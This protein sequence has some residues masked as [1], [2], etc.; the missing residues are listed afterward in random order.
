MSSDNDDKLGPMMDEFLSRKRK[1]EYPSLSEFVQRHP[2]LENEIR[3]LFPAI[4]MMEQAEVSEPPHRHA[5]VMTSNGKKLNRL[6]DYRII[7]EIGR[8]GM[9]V[10]YEAIQESLGRHVAIKLLPWQVTPGDTQARRFQREARIAASL[11]H[12]NIVP[13]YG[14]GYADS[15]HFLA[16]QFIH[17]QSL[18]SVLQELRHIQR[19]KDHSHIQARSPSQ[20]T[21]ATGRTAAAPDGRSATD[22]ATR[23]SHVIANS[24]V[25]GRD[26]NDGQNVSSTSRS[27]APQSGG[28]AA[29]SVSVL[30]SSSGRISNVL[31]YRRIAELMASVADALDFAHMQGVLHRDIKP[32]NLMLDIEGGIWITDFGLAKAGD[33]TDSHDNRFDEDFDALTQSGDIVGTLRYLAPERFRGSNDRRSDVYSLG[34]TLYEFLTLEPAF[35]NAD[36]ATLIHAITT[37]SCPAPRTI[38]ADIP[39]DLE[40]IV[41]KATQADPG[42]RYQSARDMA[43]DLRRFLDAKPIVA[44]RSS[45]LKRIQLWCRRNP[46]VAALSC[47]AFSLLLMIA[48]VSTYS[49]IELSHRQSKLTESLGRAIDA[50]ARERSA[51]RMAT[52]NLFDAYAA[53]AGSG[54]ESHRPGRRFDGLEAISNASALRD[55]IAV[56]DDDVMKL[57][58][59]AIACMGLADIAL[60]VDR[61]DEGT[62]CPFNRWGFD[63]RIEHYARISSSTGIEI[64]TVADGETVAHF[65]N[66]WS[67]TYPPFT[68]FSPDDRYVAIL[69]WH[70]YQ[71][72]AIEIWDTRDGS[73]ILPAVSVDAE[74]YSRSIA[75][76]GDSKLAAFPGRNQIL[77]FNLEMRR[78]VGI[79]PVDVSPAF[80]RFSAADSRVVIGLNNKVGV[81]DLQTT[82][83]MEILEHTQYVADAAF[84]HSGRYLAT[85]CYDHQVYVWNLE[86]RAGPVTTCSGH[87]SKALRVEF[88][89][90]DQLLM[91]NAW[92]DT[93]R[94]WNPWSGQQ[95]IR[96]ERYASRFSSDGLRIA[97]QDT[98]VSVGRWRVADSIACR[99]LGWKSGDFGIYDAAFNQSS[100]LLAH[101]AA[102]QVVIRDWP[103]GEVRYV[104]PFESKTVQCQFAQDDRFLYCSGHSHFARWNCRHFADGNSMDA[105][106]SRQS[107]S[108]STTV[109]FDLTRDSRSG[110]IH[111]SNRGVQQLT[112]TDADMQ[113]GAEVP[114]HPDEWIIET[115]DDGSLYALAG[116]HLD[117]VRVLQNSDH[118]V[119]FEYQL[120]GAVSADALFSPNGRWLLLSTRRKAMIF[121]TSN[122]Q[123]NCEIPLSNSGFGRGA[124]T[125]DESMLALQDGEGVRLVQTSPFRTLAWLQNPYGESFSAAGPE[126]TFALAFSPDQNYLACGTG[127]KTESMYVWNLQYVRQ[128]LADMD[129]DWSL[130]DRPQNSRP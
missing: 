108:S 106:A 121:D 43:L 93:S 20:S 84:S 110:L 34:L 45:S 77:I 115:S 82:D 14:V 125:Q 36:R 78:V 104:L 127:G 61:K 69:G 83:P 27:P 114:S 16:M 12:T 55:Q 48:I 44:R 91:S 17:G 25:M 85:A 118:T 113:L 18:N 117:T 30:P 62:Y 7:R 97:L 29:S 38:A 95:V 35:A 57:R 74:W 120:P 13:V 76:S 89:P 112:L 86:Q 64:R 92:D 24:L 58:N 37:T 67:H 2:E 8:G 42:L 116:K 65:S 75:F 122:W 53:R 63:S 21:P 94:F 87:T 32:A 40:T 70:S 9:G 3:E 90:D 88:S 22:A 54:R 49:V 72:C 60:E 68:C 46:T 99:V 79:R 66:G 123:L 39:Q 28:S 41:V 50:E 1:G 109:T 81:F 51:N 130:T 52:L 124:F 47:L 6:G 56:D 103:S 128:Q 129:L 33:T 98:G 107:V 101:T 111:T 10:V 31:L 4:A 96:V 119:V 80:I 26:I 11:H 126:A 23:E 15:I 19:A 5:G 102:D 100:T 71:G 105:S 59:E 73:V